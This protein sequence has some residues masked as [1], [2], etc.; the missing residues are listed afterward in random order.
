MG[1]N[2]HVYC[3]DGMIYACTVSH[4]FERGLFHE[5]T[6]IQPSIGSYYIEVGETSF[7]LIS[8]KEYLK[9]TK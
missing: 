2:T 7:K 6:E 4:L 9:K 1:T 8:K 3:P 5:E